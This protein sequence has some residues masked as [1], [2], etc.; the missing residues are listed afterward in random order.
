M[1]LGAVGP[2]ALGKATDESILGQTAQDKNPNRFRLERFGK[3]MSGSVSWEAPSAVLNG[4][5]FF[6]A[7]FAHI[8]TICIAPCCISSL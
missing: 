2:A 1:G 7:V 3:A 5:Y 8:S 4:R 6:S